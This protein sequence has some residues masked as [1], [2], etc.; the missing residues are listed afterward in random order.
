L[1]R[2]WKNHEFKEVKKERIINV[3]RPLNE[4]REYDF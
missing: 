3:V 1:I 4:M 2:K